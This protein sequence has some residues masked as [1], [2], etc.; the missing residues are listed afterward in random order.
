[1]K[2]NKRVLKSNLK[3]IDAHRITAKEYEEI[4]ELTDEFFKRADVYKGKKL[5]R[6]GR[7]LGS[8]KKVSTTVRFDADVLNSFRMQG[9][10]WQTRMNNALR[11][12]LKAHLPAA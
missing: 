10:G 1:M 4:P 2:E 6:R 11:E 12:W 9:T 5:V 3:K 8:G 7:P